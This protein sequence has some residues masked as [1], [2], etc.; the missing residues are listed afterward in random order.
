MMPSF[1]MT[2]KLLVLTYSEVTSSFLSQMNK[3]YFGVITF[4][5]YFANSES[6][7]NLD[8]SHRLRNCDTNT[9]G[10]PT[11]LSSSIGL[12]TSLSTSNFSPT[13]LNVNDGVYCLSFENYVPRESEASLNININIKPFFFQKLI[14]FFISELKSFKV[15]TRSNKYE[16]IHDHLLSF[17]NFL[18]TL[19]HTV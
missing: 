2:C 9:F 18:F 11:I 4:W 3:C 19:F 16:L 12:S 10:S 1:H 5:H 15:S 8:F 6:S 7:W 13:I 14:T 17:V